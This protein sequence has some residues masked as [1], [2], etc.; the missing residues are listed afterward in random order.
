[1][2]QD[3]D[4]AVQTQGDGDHRD[5][6]DDANDDQLPH[7]ALRDAEH[8]VDPTVDLQGAH[9]EGDRDAEDR[10]D[11]GD[12]VDE[13][14]DRPVDPL[15]EKRLEDRADTR[16]QVPLMDEVGETQ[17]RKGEDRPGV[18]GEMVEREVYRIRGSAYRFR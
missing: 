8:A 3:L 4:A 10:T 15:A 17:C 6:A 12:D 13:L 11:D 2:G 1:V 16:R 7:G 18:Q 14:A 9:T 5:P